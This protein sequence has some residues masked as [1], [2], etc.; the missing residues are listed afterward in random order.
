M[1]RARPDDSLATVSVTPEHG[2]A[3][4]TGASSGIGRALALR[5]A[6]AGW[7]V[8]ASARRAEPLASLADEAVDLPGTIRSVPLDVTDG[9]A[10]QT[11][12]QGLEQNLGPV[13]LAV[14]NA[15]THKPVRAAGFSADDARDL[16]D[17]NLIGTARCLEAVLPS[18]IAR[19]QGQIAL[20]AS[21]AGYFGLPTSAIYGASKAG[22]INMA[23]ALKPDLDGLGVQ[24]QL[25]CPGFV[26]TPLT[27][28]NDFPMPFLMELED[29]AEAFYRGLL[30]DRFEIVFP[31]R[32]AYLM[33]AVRL[34]PY[35]LFF[36]LTR[37]MLPKD[38]G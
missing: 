13:A 6:Q 30:S 35:P 21:V 37:R 25:V 2:C 12:L 29:A 20:V 9:A 36:A 18:M 7:R 23:E 11:A 3:W 19:R 24:L 28:K 17:L 15:G 1:T 10:V 26:R 8:A 5:L 34:L 4:I 33:K 31:R 32:L 22:L 27:D 38:R 14:L 16:L